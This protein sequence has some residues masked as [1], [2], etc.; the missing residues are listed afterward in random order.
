[1]SKWMSVALLGVSFAICG[2]ESMKKDKSTDSSTE[3]KK[4]SVSGTKEC[5]DGKSCCDKK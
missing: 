2:C 3:P 1:M 4:M 5:A